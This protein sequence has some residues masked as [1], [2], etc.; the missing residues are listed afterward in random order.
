MDNPAF[1][2]VEGHP[3]QCKH[4]PLSDSETAVLLREEGIELSQIPPIFADDP[5]LE[6]IR[7]PVGTVIEVTRPE[8]FGFPEHRYYRRIIIGW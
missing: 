4:R 5:A 1:F 2:R 3:L 6:S 8:V 7:A